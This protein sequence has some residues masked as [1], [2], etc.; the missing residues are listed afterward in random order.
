MREKSKDFGEG[1]SL[2][3]V[4]AVQRTLNI[5]DLS[6]VEGEEEDDSGVFS[7]V[8]TESDFRQ[9]NDLV[10][11]LVAVEGLEKERRVL[12]EEE[13]DRLKRFL[14]YIIELIC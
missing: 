12:L 14:H 9:P 1:I 10:E 6:E 7:P 5:E 11:P 4:N 13:L 2:L 8:K 3:H